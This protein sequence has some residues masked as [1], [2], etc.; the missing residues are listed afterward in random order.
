MLRFL[1]YIAA[2]YASGFAIGMPL[3]M[4]LAV[5]FARRLAPLSKRINSLVPADRSEPTPNMIDGMHIRWASRALVGVGSAI[6]CGLG[7]AGYI[8]LADY[9]PGSVVQFVFLLCA[10]SFWE[11]KV[12]LAIPALAGFWLGAGLFGS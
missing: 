3:G 8:A 1:G 9:H 12:L 2:V 4:L 5:V 11:F 10:I 7:A 6:G